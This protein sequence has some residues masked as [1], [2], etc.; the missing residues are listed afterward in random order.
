MKTFIKAALFFFVAVV[1]FVT[2]TA[3]QSMEL[4][5]F[6]QSVT[7]GAFVFFVLPD[8]PRD[9]SDKSP[10]MNSELLVALKTDVISI[11]TPD[12]NNEIATIVFAAGKGFQ[13]LQAMQGSADLKETA[14]GDP[15]AK[16]YDIELPHKY[17]GLSQ[18]SISYFSN[19]LNEE[20]IVLVRDCKNNTV[21]VIGDL[22]QGAYFDAQVATTGPDRKG[23]EN[24][25]KWRNGRPC[26][27]F[28]GTI[29]EQSGS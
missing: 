8:L 21:R 6:A 5:L 23:W 17:G 19:I 24:T 15:G 1:A 12:A 4:P 18:T 22:C 28:T 13:K 16:Y 3:M 25:I 29:D 14:A 9:T 11:S 2:A 7:A 10:G 26:A 27:F 20:L